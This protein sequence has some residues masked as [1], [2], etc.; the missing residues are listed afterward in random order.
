[1]TYHVTAWARMTILA[2][3][4]GTRTV[5]VERGTVMGYRIGVGTTGDGPDPE[6]IVECGDSDEAMLGLME[7]LRAELDYLAEWASARDDDAMAHYGIGTLKGKL[8]SADIFAETW[9]IRDAVDSGDALCC[10]LDV[11]VRRQAPLYADD[12]EAW[13]QEVGRL[14]GLFPYR[15]PGNR[16]VYWWEPDASSE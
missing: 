15:L 2:H 5:R 4:V 3:A 14:M 11:D 10:N 1:M 7:L 12:T 13:A 9:A 16:S 8:T 6:T